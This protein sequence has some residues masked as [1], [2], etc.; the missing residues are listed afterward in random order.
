MILE[1]SFGWEWVCEELERAGLDPM[2]A[3]SRKVAAWRSARGMAKSNR[4]DADL[5]SELAG[6]KQRWWQVW[7]PPI[8][9]RDRRERMR[10][11]MSLVRQQ[12]GL[13][14]RIHAI[15]HRHGIVHD[16]SDLFG[17]A[18]R[19]MLT[20]LANDRKDARLREA[21][22]VMLKGY[23]QLLDHVRLQLAAATRSIHREL[24]STPTAG[25]AIG[26]EDTSSWGTNSAG[27]RTPSARSRR[28]IATIRRCGRDRRRTER[29]KA[30]NAGVPAEHRGTLVRER[31]SPT[32][33]WSKSGNRLRTSWYMGRPHRTRSWAASSPP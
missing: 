13:K 28:S 7:L 29:R 3:S 19:R 5:L 32:T 21:A 10:Y 2:L 17:I 31:A 8:E 26:I 33:A 24:R 20:R 11:R 25:R 27:R 1:S 9:V 15:L 23:L 18:G 6:E 16:L 14:N 4:T 22:R 12:T 30:A